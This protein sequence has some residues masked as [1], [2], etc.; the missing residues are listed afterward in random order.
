MRFLRFDM[1]STRLSQF[2][3]DK[4]VLISPVWDRFIEKCIVCYK[5]EQNINVNK[6]LFPT[7]ACCRFIQYM[8]NKPKKFGI[9][10]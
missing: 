7:K 3:T 4:F 2:Q 8:A 6:Q 9:K 10:F 1:R 5:L